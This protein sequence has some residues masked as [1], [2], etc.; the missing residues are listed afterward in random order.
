M[1]EESTQLTNTEI[2]MF[3]IGWQGGTVH[4]VASAIGISVQ[5]ILD[6]DGDRMRDYVR[7]AQEVKNYRL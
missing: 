4:Q 7:R 1:N 6:A 2:L 5:D 3:V